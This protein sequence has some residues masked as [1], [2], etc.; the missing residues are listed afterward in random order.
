M[1]KIATLLFLF[2]SLSLLAVAQPCNDRQTNGSNFDWTSQTFTIYTLSHGVQSITSPFYNY[3]L[4]NL[5][6]NEFSQYA[7]KDFQS[8]EWVFIKKDFGSP[9]SGTDFAYLIL[10]NKY[11]GTLR[12]F[13]AFG[14]LYGQNDA[15]NMT[16]TYNNQSYRS[17]IFDNYGGIGTSVQDFS[18]N[19]PPISINNFYNNSILYWYHA[20]FTLNYDPCVCN[21]VQSLL[22]RIKFSS[23]ANLQFSIDGTALQNIDNYGRNGSNGGTSTSGSLAGTFNNLQ[24]AA[25]GFGNTLESLS[26]NLTLTERQTKFFKSLTGDVSGLGSILGAANFLIGL[27]DNG[28]SAPIKPLAFDINLKGT[29]SIVYTNPYGSIQLPVS[30]ANKS[31][32]DVNTLPYY[33]NALGV[34]NLLTTP[35]TYEKGVQYYD[36]GDNGGVGDG[37]YWELNY[38]YNLSI[39]NDIKYVIN[40]NAG[41][42]SD[43]QYIKVY[44]SY[45]YKY[46]DEDVE[47]ETD[48][49]PLGCVKDYKLYLWESIYQSDRGANFRHQIEYVY[50]RV[51]AKLKTA[52]LTKDVVLTRKY[53][54]NRTDLVWG[55][56]ISNDVIPDV[57]CN[58]FTL[59][60]PDTEIAA[61]CSSQPYINRAAAYLRIIH[62]PEV[63]LRNS[64]SI[65]DVNRNK[66]TITPNPMITGLGKAIVELK[67]SGPIKLYII[68]ASGRKIRELINSANFNKGVFSV[69]LNFTGLSKGIYLGILETK[70]GRLSQKIIF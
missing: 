47:H 55:D 59:P 51:T 24:K 9:T 1:K 49:Y 63:V 42:S 57:N 14:Q 43:P 61:V 35:V 62:V 12:V 56:Y 38:F 4:N 34:F 46:G 25:T 5:N 16:L 39:P 15:I 6:T 2:L 67:E 18:N 26:K 28:T 69:D 66:L 22:F 23:T 7:N 40:P 33:D 54:I 13:Y 37:A 20:D 48:S 21:H 8:P 19:I 27:L 64:N 29:G 41:L 44:A 30:G 45:I 10:Y 52:D 11:S 17:A 68:D 31:G 50:L 32:L 65:K 70:N 58:T 3:S 53:N 60:A 36:G